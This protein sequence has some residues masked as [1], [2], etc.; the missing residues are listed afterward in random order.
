MDSVT[1]AHPH[2]HINPVH[3]SIE[4]TGLHYRINLNINRGAGQT[5]KNK[6]TA[7]MQMIIYSH[8]PMLSLSSRVISS[9]IARTTTK[10][11]LP[12]RRITHHKQISHT[13]SH[14]FFH[15]SVKEFPVKVS[16]RQPNSVTRARE[17]RNP[18][19]SQSQLDGVFTCPLSSG[20][21]VSGAVG[22]VDVRNF[23]DQWVVGIGVSEHRADRQQD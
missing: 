11:S 3:T 21:L 14:S 6:L 12:Q 23:G 19:N 16:R 15:T 4:G 8:P 20:C 7:R 17:K 5:R 9:C 22:L 10:V 13:S 18:A 1:R 2:Y